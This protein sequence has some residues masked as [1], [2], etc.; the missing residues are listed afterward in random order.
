MTTKYIST[1]ELPVDVTE[2]LKL[3]DPILPKNIQ[4]EC[5]IR[6]NY[7]IINEFFDIETLE[8][9]RICVVNGR[10]Y[11]DHK[12]IGC[13]KYI[14]ETKDREYNYCLDCHTALC[15]KCYKKKNVRI[16]NII[17]Q[18]LTHHMKQIKDVVIF[19]KEISI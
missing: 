11:S 13:K 16:T 19:V 8:D 6:N 2:P 4:S 14:F 3:D 10:G 15:N 9:M 12:C 18:N 7:E 1:D 5:L 17:M